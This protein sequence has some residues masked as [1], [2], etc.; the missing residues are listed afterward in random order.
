MLVNR[1]TANFEH[2]HNTLIIRPVKSQL[3]FARVERWLRQ[4]NIPKKQLPTK[5]QLA[6]T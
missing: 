5:R 4:Q 2:S 1:S 6:A 3:L